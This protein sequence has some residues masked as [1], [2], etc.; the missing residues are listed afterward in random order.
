MRAKGISVH[1]N[2]QYTGSN[3]G[4]N[5]PMVIYLS[6]LS[7]LL[8]LRELLLWQAFFM[9]V[10]RHFPAYNLG[11]QGWGCWGGVQDSLKI[12]PQ[13]NPLFPGEH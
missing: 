12:H 2:G 3:N 11:H 10:L 9:L 13:K 8:G 5:L 1:V 6:V 7:E 4:T